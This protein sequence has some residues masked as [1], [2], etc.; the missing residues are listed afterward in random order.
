IVMQPVDD[1][2]TQGTGITV[3]RRPSDQKDMSG[4]FAQSAC[5]AIG[6]AQSGV[7]F[8]VPGDDTDCD[9]ATKECPGNDFD[10]C[11][12]GPPHGRSAFQCL[13]EPGGHGTA[14]R[15]AGFG[16]ADN[17]PA[18][19]QSTIDPKTCTAIDDF[20]GCVP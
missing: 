17:G 9:G 16:C 19:K 11:F 3:W 13:A 2:L 12:S 1:L 15:L 8:F 14:C 18:C 10:Y 7:E 4:H 6:D 5:A 20:E